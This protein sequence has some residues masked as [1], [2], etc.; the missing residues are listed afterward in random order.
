[1]NIYSRDLSHFVDRE[2]LWMDTGCTQNVPE[3]ERRW[4]WCLS[5]THW[6]LCFVS[7]WQLLSQRV[8]SLFQAIHTHVRVQ[9]HTILLLFMELI[10]TVCLLTESLTH[11]SVNAVVL[12]YIPSFCYLLL[13]VVVNILILIKTPNPLLIMSIESSNL[14]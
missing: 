4:I 9:F 3:P 6:A 1:M 13:G 12:E 10:S 11:A 14:E 7:M 2:Q 8:K 5:D